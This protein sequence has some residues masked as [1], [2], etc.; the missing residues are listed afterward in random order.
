M[1]TIRFAKKIPE[2]TVAQGANLMEELLLA[3]LP[4]A[5]SCHGDGICGK[6]RVRVLKGAENLSKI[7]PLEELVRDRLKVPVGF[8]ISCQTQVLGDIE[9]DTT[10]W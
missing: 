10:Y 4:V 7:V 3:S 6:C 8:R 2:I 9:I 5:S 1:P